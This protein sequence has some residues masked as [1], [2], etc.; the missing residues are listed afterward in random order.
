MINF[1][2]LLEQVLNEAIPL[3]TTKKMQ[4]NRKN[5]GA[6][7]SEKLN[8]VFGGK[9]RLIF[10][11]S[12]DGKQLEDKEGE[13]FFKE[14]WDFFQNNHVDVDFDQDMFDRGLV[15][16]LDKKTGDF[17]YKNPT[18]LGKFLTKINATEMLNKWRNYTSDYLKD[19]KY[20]VIISRHP[21]DVAGMSTDRNWTSCMDLGV[22]GPVYKKHNTRGVHSGD[23]KEDVKRGTIVA[24]LV[25][26]KDKLPSGKFEIRRPY[27]RIL[28]KPAYN[29]EGIVAYTLGQIYGVPSSEFKKFVLDWLLNGLDKDSPDGEYKLTDGLYVDR[30]TLPFNGQLVEFFETD[31]Q[32]LKDYLFKNPNNQ[33]NEKNIRIRPKFETRGVDITF[34][35]PNI[36]LDAR[37]KNSPDVENEIGVMEPI[38]IRS[39]FNMTSIF[40]R[41]SYDKLADQLQNPHFLNGFDYEKIKKDL[42]KFS[43]KT[44]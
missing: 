12:M 2:F 41:V 39:Y 32:K 4:L 26:D 24:Y 10:P 3:A 31:L 28:M 43:T 6:Y 34:E 37:F 17:N 22:K 1:K 5:S 19:K 14:L 27:S 42:L 16:E 30:E 25:S 13:M 29:Q 15:Y 40:T 36:V 38:Y 11:L 35:Y 20:Y 8:Q 9:D 33:K 44:Q 21:Y 18:R 7:N 23:I